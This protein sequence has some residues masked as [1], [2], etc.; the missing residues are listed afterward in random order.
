[1]KVLHVVATA[2]R[3]G[4]ELFASA[5]VGSLAAEGIEQE[6]VILRSETESRVRFAAPTTILWNGGRAL[7]WIRMSAG[8]LRALQDMM[9]ASRPDVIQAHGGEPLKYVM[10]ATHGRGRRVVYRRIGDAVPFTGR[11]ASARGYAA[12]IRRTARIVAVGDAL[13]DE[14]LE[15]F[16]LDATKIVTIPNAVD[17]RSLVPAR[18]RSEVR[19][20]LGIEDHR[21]VILSLGALTWEKDPV[22]HLRVARRVADQIPSL[23]HML[24]GDGPLR[25][26]VETEARRLGAE[27]RTILLGSRDDIADLLAAS[28]LLLL[29]SKSEGM[30]ASL[31]EAGMLGI[32]VAAYAISGVPEVVMDGETGALVPSGDEE[33]LAGAVIGLLEDDGRRK[34]LGAAARNRCRSRFDI[35][36]V[37]PLYTQVYEEV[38]RGES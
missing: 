17:G 21:P 24:A 26:H 28:D 10:A 23:V 11:R 33:G 14:L 5:L 8:R 32:P 6:V 7:P 36:A 22:G 37:A 35:S 9:T 12:L 4:G 20:A 34:D 3:R 2:Q 18:S 16:K 19:A 13:R 25:G 31:I 29:A 38:A 15:R 1:M 27:D 30:P